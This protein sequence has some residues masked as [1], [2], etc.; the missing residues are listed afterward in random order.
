MLWIRNES[1]SDV[2]SS[3][4]DPGPEWSQSF[5]GG[6]QITKSATGTLKTPWVSTVPYWCGT[7]VSVIADE[8]G[9]FFMYKIAENDQI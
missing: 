8:Y 3:D 9:S 1:R 7:S 6:K 5:A 4:L 2:E